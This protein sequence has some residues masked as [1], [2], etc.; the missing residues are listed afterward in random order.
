M[1]AADPTYLLM[2]A[3]LGAWLY[4]IIHNPRRDP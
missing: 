1:S 3:L 4:L 2:C